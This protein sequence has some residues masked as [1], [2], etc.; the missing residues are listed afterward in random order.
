MARYLTST[1]LGSKLNEAAV[2][3]AKICADLRAA[4][5]RQ[6]PR[7]L[8]A[9][10]TGVGGL[11]FLAVAAMSSN[12][13]LLSVSGPDADV[14]FGAIGAIVLGLSI[15][16]TLS[17][18][19]HRVRW[20][21]DLARGYWRVLVLPYARDAVLVWDTLAKEQEGVALFEMD[22]G[23]LQHLAETVQGSCACLDDESSL[24]SALGQVRDAL[25]TIRPE[26]LQT[27][28]IARQSPLAQFLRPLIAATQPASRPVLRHMAILP[29]HDGGE[30]TTYVSVT[31]RLG[32]FMRSSYCQVLEGVGNWIKEQGEVALGTLDTKER[33]YAETASAFE[34]KGSGYDPGLRKDLQRALDELFQPVLKGLNAEVAPELNRLEQRT[35]QDSDEI[36]ARHGRRKRALTNEYELERLTLDNTIAEL[37]VRLKEAQRK[38]EAAKQAPI[39]ES[40]TYEATVPSVT[41]MLR[42]FQSKFDRQS[43]ARRE[44]ESTRSLLDQKQKQKRELET[45]FE[46]K[47]AEYKRQEQAAMQEVLE[48]QKRERQRLVQHIDQ[49]QAEQAKLSSLAGAQDKKLPASEFSDLFAHLFDTLEKKK[50]ERVG[51][52]PVAVARALVRYRAQAVRSLQSDVAT[53]INDLEA[54]VRT[55][56]AKMEQAH[57]PAEG[58]PEVPGEYFIPVWFARFRGWRQGVWQPFLSVSEL[59]TVEIGPHHDLGFTLNDEPCRALLDHLTKVLDSSSLDAC[60]SERSLLDTEFQRKHLWEEIIAMQESRLI[61]EQLVKTVEAVLRS[62]EARK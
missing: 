52:D 37:E 60:F 43:A 51:E 11:L 19:R 12:K 16:L 62:A 24:V 5:Q 53:V 41:G 18:V 23:K 35:K 40:A 27:A 1:F 20:P 39:S 46:S 58:F 56:E 7:V 15:W 45:K 25:R 26:V 3:L 57:W 21:D 2:V 47:M 31:D 30:L 13:R 36:Q 6:R 34:G 32:R 38:L 33:G 22:V 14:V 29:A 59:Q 48:R 10:G 4:R 44:V 8:A 49:I 42:G 50:E 55:T 28:F 61:S 17:V 54:Q 9:V